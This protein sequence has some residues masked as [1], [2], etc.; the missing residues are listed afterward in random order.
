MRRLAPLA[1]AAVTLLGLGACAP[2]PLGV[3][4]SS[5]GS[6][7]S[8]A[9]APTS[10]SGGAATAPSATPAPASTPSVPACVALAR[11]LTPA[12][13]VGQLFMMGVDTGGLD[14]TTRAAITNN[15]VGS[16]VLLGNSGEGRSAIRSLTAELGSLGTAELPLLVAADQEGGAVQRLKGEGFGTIPPAREQGQWDTQELTARAAEWGEA[17]KRAGVDYDLAPVAD[18][19]PESK[20]ATN[21][22]IGKLKRDFGADPAKVAASVV[23][24]VDGLRESGVVAAAKHF[25]GLGEVTNNTDFGAA[26]DTVTTADSPNLEPFRAAISSGISSIMVSSAVFEKIDPDNEG[27]FSSAVITDLLRGQLGFDGVVIADDLGAAKAVSDVTPANR[28][29]RFFEAG[30][31]LAI[32]ADPRIMADMTDAT[33]QRAEA[34]EAFA[35]RVEQSAAR[36]LQLKQDAGILTC[37]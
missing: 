33:L 15:S 28:A 16:V 20:R 24:V 6:R 22:P 27:V 5:G 25:P 19:V 35:A 1:V 23:A 13:R 10:T 32:N 34:D 29:L 9:T 17:L 21:A 31:D 12:E 4:V 18:V 26:L 36:V 11:S 2:E 30:G 8:G 7:D 37:G 14:E 3:H